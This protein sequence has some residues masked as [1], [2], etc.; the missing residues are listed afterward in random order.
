MALLDPQVH[1]QMAPLLEALGETETPPVGDVEARRISGHRMMDHVA[2]TRQPAR[3]CRRRTASLTAADG[4]ALDATWYRRSTGDRPGSAVLYLHGGGMI[5]GLEH[6]GAMCDLAVRGY[7]AASG[8]PMLVVDYRIRTRAP[9]PDSR[10]RLLC[11]AGVAG[12]AGDDAGCRP[13]P[14]GRDGRKRRRR[15]GGRCVPDGARPRWARRCPAAADL[16]DA[17]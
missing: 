8:V 14:A 5:F 3:G 10:R 6:I 7:V 15:A 9:T 13:G 12:R 11:R 1:A 16:P 17:R 4:A 2:A